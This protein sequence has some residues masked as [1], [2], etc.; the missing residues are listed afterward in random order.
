MA[1]R[2]DPFERKKP[3][4]K[5][6]PTVLV[7]CEDKK[8]SLQYLTDAA[9]HFRSHAKVEIA[10]PNKHDPLSIVGEAIN[11][12]NH[13]DEIYC[14]IDRDQHETFDAALAR[15][16]DQNKIKVIPSYPCYEYWLLLHFKLSRKPHV[17]VGNKSSCDLQT[18]DL[19]L[20]NDMGNYAKGKSNGLFTNLLERLPTARKHAKATLTAAI[21][22][23]ELNPSTKIHE[24]IEQ[25]EKLGEPQL[26]D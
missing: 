2:P 25:L 14:V 1:R 13:F 18:D 5:P 24:L 9:H 6:Q 12:Q 22:A 17:S 26:I 10:H 16:K 19:R 11:R 3:K 15:S 4:F 23:E 20:E 7:L 8:S 21:N